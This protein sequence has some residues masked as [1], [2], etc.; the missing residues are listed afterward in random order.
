MV[1]WTKRK[2]G[3]QRSLIVSSMEGA[4]CIL[5]LQ[6][7]FV[8]YISHT[9]SD[10]VFFPTSTVNKTQQTERCIKHAHDCF[11]N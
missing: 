2:R 9:K 8:L 4:I 1:L 3:K 6:L 5:G 11:L 7:D 10:N